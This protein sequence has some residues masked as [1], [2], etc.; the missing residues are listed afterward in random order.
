MIPF[1]LK[2]LPI[3]NKSTCPSLP[4]SYCSGDKQLDSATCDC[5]CTHP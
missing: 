5:N 2:F 4:L 3:K 1:N